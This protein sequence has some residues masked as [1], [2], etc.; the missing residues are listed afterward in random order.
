MAL[1]I[2]MARA[3]NVNSFG[4]YALAIT[5]MG[6]FKVIADFGTTFFTTH[7]M[8]KNREQATSLFI[9]GLILKLIISCVGLGILV[10]LTKIFY[11]PKVQVA[12]LVGGIAAIIRLIIE[13][14]SS[15]FAGLEKMK[16]VSVIMVM[17]MSL[18][19]LVTLIMLAIGIRVPST[20][21]MGYLIGGLI[22]LPF[23]TVIFF[24]HIRLG[25][26]S[27]QLYELKRLFVLAIPFGLYF[28]SD[29]I[30][31]HTDVLM[32]SV[33]KGEHSV[34]LYQSAMKLNQ[35]LEAAP[36]L[37]ASALFPTISRTFIDSK[38]KVKG[39]L[40]KSLEFILILGIPLAVGGFILAKP[41][42]LTIFSNKYAEAILILKI[43]MIMVPFRFAGF[44]FGMVLTASGNQSKRMLVVAATAVIN[45]I[46]NALW[47][48][49]WGVDGAAAASVVSAIVLTF[50]Y[51]IFAKSLWNIQPLIIQLFKICIATTV[52][53]LTIYFVGPN[54]NIWICLSGAIIIYFISL[55]L[56][57]GIRNSD[58]LYM[59]QLLKKT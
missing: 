39:M 32:L 28:L 9:H 48:P 24:K 12:I 41:L 52:M 14:Q 23:S 53:A 22:A 56:I 40:G 2:L 13:F 35:L 15:F 36:L 17:Y 19:V 30:Y 50:A 7:E 25:E 47:I 21:V 27:I 45:V 5:V 4:V 34:G 1:T 8:A 38:E 43:L 16:F 3:L 20:L 58:W 54:L 11:E 44:I 46:L 37:L 55:I 6:L 10:V 59:K 29:I 42:M 49:R 18:V 57:K 26:I 33:M 31:F 51:A